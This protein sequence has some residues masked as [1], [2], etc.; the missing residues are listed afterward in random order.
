MNMHRSA[1]HTFPIIVERDEDGLFV[2]TNPA[3]VGCS[4]QGATIEEALQNIKEA[5]LLCMEGDVS[6]VTETPR[7]VSIHLI[8]T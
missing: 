5:T 8:A 4:S 6:D 1:A 2:A 3:F 7:D